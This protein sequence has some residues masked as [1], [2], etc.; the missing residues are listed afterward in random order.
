[1]GFPTLMSNLRTATTSMVQRRRGRQRS[2]AIRGGFTYELAS[3]HLQALFS[4]AAVDGPITQHEYDAVLGFLDR[5]SIAPDDNARLRALAPMFAQKPPH[6][7]ALLEPLAA[8]AAHPVRARTLLTDLARIAGIERR[9]H[10]RELLLMDE[11]AAAVGAPAVNLYGMTLTAQVGEARDYDRTA[12]GL[13]TQL[14]IRESVC[15]AL[16]TS[17][18]A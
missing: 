6:M 17:Y 9:A 4:M 18:A 10:P 15:R 2:T 12:V 16:E 3:L 7:E 1:M 11:Y 13:A 8:F 14:R 5:A